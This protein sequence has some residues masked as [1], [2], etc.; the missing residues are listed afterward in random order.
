MGWIRYDDGFPSHPK[1]LGIDRLQALAGWLHFRATCYCE[2]H[3]TDGFVPIA[4]VRRMD[5]FDEFSTDGLTLA[6]LLVDAGLFDE[7]EGG[8]EV[9]DY[10]DYNRSKAEVRAAKD[11][12]SKAARSR[13]RNAEGNANRNA[14]GITKGNAKGN[15]DRRT[16]QTDETDVS[17]PPAKSSF[18]PCMTSDRW[19]FSG[20]EHKSSRAH[21]A[22]AVESKHCHPMT[23]SEDG[24]IGAA[25]KQVCPSGCTGSASVKCATEMIDKIEKAH[26]VKTACAFYVS[27]RKG[28]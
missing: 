28:A 24:M 2:Q 6:G 15:A 27:D 26:T 22:E 23:T 17:L 25:I 7:V 12:A 18:P 20:G 3:L 4:W 21:I 13:W 14:E 16:R 11:A 10:L 8:F 5:D 19:A 1:L 9:H